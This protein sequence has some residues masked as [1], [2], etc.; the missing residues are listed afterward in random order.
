MSY[1]DPQSEYLAYFN[2]LFQ[3]WENTLSD[4][5][6]KHSNE[7]IFKNNSKRL[8]DCKIEFSKY[9]TDIMNKSITTCAKGGSCMVDRKH[10]KANYLHHN[11]KTSG[12]KNSGE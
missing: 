10:R 5:M 4:T 2:K 6:F 7:V 9:M 8:S 11:Y 12:H 3:L 1:K